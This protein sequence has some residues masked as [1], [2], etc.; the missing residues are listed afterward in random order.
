[1]GWKKALKKNDIDISFVSIS[2][3][4]NVNIYKQ[5]PD[6]FYDA[7]NGDISAQYRAGVYLYNGGKYMKQ[8]LSDAAYW[9]K[10][11]ADKGHAP[12]QYGLAKCLDCSR[13]LSTQ[14]KRVYWNNMGKEAF[15]YYEEAANKGFAPAQYALG[16]IYEAIGRAEFE[17]L[18][19][20]LYFSYK[21]YTHHFPNE[22]I[23]WYRK[24]AEQGYHSALEA[25]FIMY[26]FKEEHKIGDL[27][28]INYMLNQIGKWQEE[29]KY[30]GEDF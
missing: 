29:V 19:Y 18:N 8:N 15:R 21:F 6:Y 2:P 12:S 1:M 28:H 14:A 7:D 20:E 30:V 9:F 17:T 25:L 10:R 23:A 3:T 5:I 13:G 4:F 16:K 22:A 27:V 11:A 24:A 26:S